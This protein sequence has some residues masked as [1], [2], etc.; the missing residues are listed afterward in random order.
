MNVTSTNRPLPMQQLSSTLETAE[1]A[2]ASA[3]RGAGG[4]SELMKDLFQVAQQ[5]QNLISLIGQYNGGTLPQCDPSDL[6]GCCPKPQP[7]PK[8]LEKLAT[9][10]Y[11]QQLGRE[12]TAKELEHATD[13]A[14]AMRSHGC[15]DKQIR[16]ELTRQVRSTPEFKSGKGLAEM[17]E[18]LYNDLLLRAS[19]PAGK[20][21]WTGR[22]MDMR[23]D[24]K[25]FAEI[26][27]ALTQEFR[28][29][30]E[31]KALPK[32][33]KLV[34]DV[35]QEV[36]GHEPDPELKGS[37]VQMAKDLRGE[38]M[39]DQEVRQALIDNLKATSE[40]VS[41]KGLDKLV[42]KCL[43]KNLGWASPS[44]SKGWLMYAKELRNDGKTYREIETALNDAMKTSD[45][46]SS[47]QMLH[48]E[49]AANKQSAVA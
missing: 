21:Y 48:M 12:P 41:G 9:N 14:K 46:R 47:L 28:K 16:Q 20:K 25:S 36:L 38:G 26:K 35:Y 23:K 29:S 15:T 7:K 49:R 13:T 6:W 3:A 10:V 18:G 4:N 39:S 45:F 31:Y 17:V 22:A 5:L 2:M 44:L 27:R 32:L 43:E 40:F 33:T 11:K 19:D 37:Y 24:G 34:E 8:S 1:T 42:D 30:E